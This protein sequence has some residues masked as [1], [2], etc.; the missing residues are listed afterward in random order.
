MKLTT[1]SLPGTSSDTLPDPD[2]VPIEDIT[3]EGPD[4]VILMG[5]IKKGRPGKGTAQ[6]TSDG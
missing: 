3:N 1:E 5:Q 4:S 6:T 2:D